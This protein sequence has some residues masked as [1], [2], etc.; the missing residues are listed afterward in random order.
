MPT[1]ILDI[2]GAHGKVPIGPQYV[3]T[4]DSGET[5]IIDPNGNEHRYSDC[6]PPV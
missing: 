2:P 5:L 3:S 6:A 1:Y 4:A